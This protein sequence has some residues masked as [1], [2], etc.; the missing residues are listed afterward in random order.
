MDTATGLFDQGFSEMCLDYMDFGLADPARRAHIPKSN[1]DLGWWCILHG[2]EALS[3][4]MFN[5]LNNPSISY[6]A[7]VT[8]ISCTTDPP[9]VLVTVKGEDTP[10]TYDH[11]ICT[12]PLS[13]LST[14]DLTD[15]VLTYEQKVAIC[16]MHYDNSVKVGISFDDRWW[17][18]ADPPINGGTS[19]TDRP[20]R[21]IVYPSYGDKDSP[22]VLIAS[23]AWAQDAHRLASLIPTNGLIDKTVIPSCYIAYFSLTSPLSFSQTL[24][25]STDL[26]MPVNSST[27]SNGS[28]PTAGTTSPSAAGHSHYSVLDNSMIYMAD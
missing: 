3:D 8:K 9:G 10:R 19:S 6:N 25:P 5:Q 21:N 7:E 20:I 13:C 24:L 2:T 17:Q 23:Y 27:R 18:T 26:K 15:V 1:V 12:M 16:N 14:V 11:V 22:A 4:A 28:T